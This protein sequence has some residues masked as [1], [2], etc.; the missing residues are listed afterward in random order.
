MNTCHT[1]GLWLETME[2][3]DRSRIIKLIK[4]Q[5]LICMTVDVDN[6]LKMRTILGCFSSVG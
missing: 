3:Q 6:Q 2:A 5:V 4:L 1:T